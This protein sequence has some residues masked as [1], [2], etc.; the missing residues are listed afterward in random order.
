MSVQG[1]ETG[2]QGGKF[3]E[4][5]AEM[6]EMGN[7]PGR[8]VGSPRFS[9]GGGSVAAA[10]RRGLDRLENLLLSEKP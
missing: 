7:F 10:I 9:G 4:K 5:C 8:E 1:V 3:Y 6:G 2:I